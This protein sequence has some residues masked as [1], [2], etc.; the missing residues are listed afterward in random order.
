MIRFKKAR[1]RDINLELAISSKKEH[2][3][4]YIFNEP[5]LNSFSYEISNNR[6]EGNN[7]YTIIDELQMEPYTLEEALDK[8]LVNTQNI[9]FLPIDVEGYDYDVLISNNWEKFQPEL[10]LI[11]VLSSSLRDLIRHEVTLFLED[12][13]Y[14]IYAK[15][16]NTVIYK[17]KT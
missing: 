10:V 4:Y 8:Y 1:K 5:A 15:S 6:S 16:W 13:G 17:L 11:E 14:E 7:N 2:L 9:D 3:T 12:K